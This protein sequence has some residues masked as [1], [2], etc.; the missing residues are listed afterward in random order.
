VHAL[1][2]F[3]CGEQHQAT[4]TLTTR[5]AT[6]Q[7]VLGHAVEVV[8]RPLAHVLLLVVCDEPDAAAG[9]G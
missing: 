9:L 6:G 1:R 3:G 4:Y 8:A 2:P 5:P 7:L